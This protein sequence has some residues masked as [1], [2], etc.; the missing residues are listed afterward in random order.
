MA[1]PLDRLQRVPQLTLLFW[2]VKLLS[3][4]VG[5]TTSDYFVKTLDPVPVVLVAAV[6]FAICFVIQFT[7]RR[8][9]PWRYWLFVCMVAVFGT[10][11]ADVTHIVIGVPYLLSTIAFA[12]VLVVIFIVWR[13][14][15][16]TV[17]VHSVTTGRRELFYWA[18][19]LATFA[20]GTAVGDLT[21]TTFTLGYL[22]S[23]IVFA[24][25]IAMP[26]IAYRFHLPATI[27]FWWAYVLTRPLGASFADWLAVDHSRGGL[28]LGT[29]PIS[30]AGAALIIAGVAVMQTR[31]RRLQRL[32]ASTSEVS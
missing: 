9:V 1:S 7:A 23:G 28:A 5:E 8:Y 12:A 15:E 30:A 21:A 14:T 25:L 2:V 29:L 26:G 6:L 16:G 10:M 22:G 18:T 32:T 27:A 19:V 13:I 3:T 24:I 17:S 11:V 20:L 4:G 31:Q